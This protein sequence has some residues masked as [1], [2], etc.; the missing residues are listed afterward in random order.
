VER[1]LR[2]RPPEDR[3]P[4]KDVTPPDQHIEP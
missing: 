4:M 3:P 1:I 2:R